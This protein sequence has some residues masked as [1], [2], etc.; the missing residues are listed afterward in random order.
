M[1]IHTNMCKYLYAYIYIPV[2]T[3]KHNRT[4]ATLTK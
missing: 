2:D 3:Y 4:P 1:Y